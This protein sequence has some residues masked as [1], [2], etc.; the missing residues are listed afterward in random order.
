[1]PANNKKE[2][3]ISYGWIQ[4]EELINNDSFRNYFNKLYDFVIGSSNKKII[5]KCYNEHFINHNDLTTLVVDY[6][7]EFN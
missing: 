2:R 5:D 6:N 4:L 3:P 7:E 1:M